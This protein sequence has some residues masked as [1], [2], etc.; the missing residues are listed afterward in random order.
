MTKTTIRLRV[1]SW[2]VRWKSISSNKW[3]WVRVEH[4]TFVQPWSGWTIFLRPSHDAGSA[5]WCRGRAESCT[6]HSMMSTTYS[7]KP[8]W[9]VKGNDF[10]IFAPHDPTRHKVDYCWLNVGARWRGG[11]SSCWAMWP[12]GPC[13]VSV[14]RHK[15][16]TRT[17]HA[18]M[19][20]IYIYM[21]IYI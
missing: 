11:K 10:T 3:G 16:H 8:T 14:H 7:C 15:P 17:H 9:A 2:S 5:D 19:Y 21:Y 18:H 20:T 4:I 12:N 13:S 1:M 6:E